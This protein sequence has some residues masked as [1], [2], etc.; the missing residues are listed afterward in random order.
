MR[1]TNTF[2]IQFIIRKN[3]AKNGLAPIYA[4][5]TVDGRRI[6]MSLKQWIKPME[7]NTNKGM[8]RG[9]REEIKSLNHYLEEV[10][11]R[12]VES[13]Q[14]MQLQQMQITADAIKSMFLG[15]NQKEM[16]L[17][18]LMDYH[19]ET[20][21]EI[22]TWGTLKNYFTTQKYVKR[23]L[24]KHLGTTD[25]FLSRLSYKF[26]TE[27]EF[28]LR[29]YKPKDHHKPMSNNGVMK[30]MERLRK[31]VTMAVKMEWL[32]KDPFEKY[33][34]RFTKVERG[35]LTE[36]ELETIENTEMKNGSLL[37]VRDLFVFSCY[38]GLAYIDVKNLRPDNITLGIDG[39]KWLSTRRQ[40]TDLPVRVPLLF[41]A[42][43]LIEKYQNHP[44]AIQKGTVF[45][46]FSNQKTNS[47]L[48]EIAVLC[49]I[50]KNLTFHLARHT[51]A[52][53]VTLC[54]G[55]PMETVSK[56]LGHSKITTTQ[57]Y[58]KVVERKVSED[59]NILRTKLGEKTNPGNK[60]SI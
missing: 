26:I 47:Y 36:S 35:Y 43:Q 14:E 4:R 53:T 58:A 38:T 41:K 34:M 23:F 48:K 50:Q 7:W 57:I 17:C 56:M 31:M 33:Q 25:M 15:T 37:W 16:T 6:E 2:G 11:T 49:G 20:S 5:I 59:M 51:F 27:F 32:E 46:V 1:T 44:R 29:K 8:A 9:S 21:K 52:T 30:H 39:E 60:K 13:Y 55:V 10:R 3:K 12:L 42:W 40:K 18:K 45:P 54:N 22:L 24:K 28:Y 19:N